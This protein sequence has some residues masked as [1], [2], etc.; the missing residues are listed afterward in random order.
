MRVDV[1]APGAHVGV[2]RGDFGQ[3]VHRDLSL[4]GQMR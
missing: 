4:G 3:E 2:E 1:M